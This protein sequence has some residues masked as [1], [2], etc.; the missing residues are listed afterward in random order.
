MTMNNKTLLNNGSVMN[1]NVFQ[2]LLPSM[3]AASYIV[4]G[5]SFRPAR[6]NSIQYEMPYQEAIRIIENSAC[7]GDVKNGCGGIPRNFNILLMRPWLGAINRPHVDE[8]M[9]IDI[10]IGSK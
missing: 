6:K 10:P 9:V 2:A 8:A 5:M 7:F 4:L 3:R 1:Q